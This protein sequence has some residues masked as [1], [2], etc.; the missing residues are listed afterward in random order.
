MG[1]VRELRSGAPRIGDICHRV[2]LARLPHLARNGQRRDLHIAHHAIRYR[3]VQRLM[4]RGHRSTVNSS[5]VLQRKALGWA[6][7]GGD[8]R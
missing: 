5:P 4:M 3:V 2:D 6:N 8:I 1:L 7:P